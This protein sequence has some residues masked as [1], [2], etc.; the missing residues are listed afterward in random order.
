MRNRG[1]HPQTHTGL[2]CPLWRDRKSGAGRLAP[3]PV[4]DLAARLA[5]SVVG[6]LG[7]GRE[8]GQYSPGVRGGL[9]PAVTSTGSEGAGDSPPPSPRLPLP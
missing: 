2:V 9:C 3:A 7:W 8:G 6:V 4:W 5:R 1:L